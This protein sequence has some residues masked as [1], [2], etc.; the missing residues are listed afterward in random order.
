MENFDALPNYWDA[1]VHNIKKRTDR[2]R[3]CDSCHVAKRNFLT[4]EMIIQEEGSK[5][6]ENLI[7]DLK[8]INK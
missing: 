7:Y 8:P 6:N 3:S 2:T 4:H 5:A 1:A